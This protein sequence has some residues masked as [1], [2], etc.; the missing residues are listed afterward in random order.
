M[1]CDECGEREAS[2]H[3]TRIINDEKTEMHLCEKCAQKSSQLNTD[4]NFSFQSLL[5][6]IMNQNLANQN[7]PVF[8]DDQS[9]N[10]VCNY[11]GMSYQ[12][13]TQRGVFGCE[14]CYDAFE[15]KLD[16]LVK[17]IHGNSQHKGKYPLSLRKKIKI[18]SEINEL[19]NEMKLAV[20]KENFEKAAEIRDEI[21][22]IEENME[23]KYNAE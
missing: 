10:L 16:Q 14:G 3:L 6:G 17:R 5:S 11:C 12:E 1:I 18:K 22:A 13:F 21:H 4:N 23:E 15:G 9:Q 19:K 20:A 7:S 2:V 8:K